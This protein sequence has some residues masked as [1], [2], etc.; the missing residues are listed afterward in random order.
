[1]NLKK[2]FNPMS[3]EE[4]LEDISSL[5]KMQ[6]VQKLMSMEFIRSTMICMHCTIPMIL[7]TT[8]DSLDGFNWRCLN[9]T[10]QKYQTTRS[11]R[12]ESWL[13][14]IKICPKKILK[15]LLYWSTGKSQKAI[16]DLIEISKNTI[17]KFRKFIIYKIRTYFERVPIQLGGPGVHV[18]VDETMLNYKVKSHRGRGPREKVWC[19]SIVD[20]SYTPSKCYF[21]IV[22]NRRAETLLPII[23]RIVRQ[24]SIISTDE[25]S[26]YL[27]LGEIN[28]YV[29]QTICHKYNFVCP[30]TGVH[31]Q[32]VE[33]NNNKLKRAIKE[34][35][36]LTSVGRELLILEFMF[37]NHF[38]QDCYNTICNLLRINI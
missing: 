8:K 1:M 4:Q 14:G 19:L 6:M 15:F 27:R 9:Y 31:T 23:G 13:E 22:E 28:N 2:K 17:S 38:K 16:L 35:N 10:C 5:N 26:S 33:S 34:A 3:I 7:K 36:G 37:L 18:Q 29:H 30:V 25:F 12:C 24:G 32:H 21:E 11:I 20:T